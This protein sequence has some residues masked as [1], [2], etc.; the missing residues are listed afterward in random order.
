MKKLQVSLIVGVVVVSLFACYAFANAMLNQGG[1]DQLVQGNPMELPFGTYQS[2]MGVGSRNSSV[3]VV[4]DQADDNDKLV[5]GNPMELPNGTHESDMTPGANKCF[6]VASLVTQVDV[7]DP[8]IQGN[9][10]ELPGGTH[11]SDMVGRT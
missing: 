5:L 8:L 10:M 9:P 1:E 4:D 11:Q 6:R 7:D 2:D 3:A